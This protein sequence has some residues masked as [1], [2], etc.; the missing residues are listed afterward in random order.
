MPDC[1]PMEIAPVLALA[2]ADGVILS[3]ED[4]DVGGLGSE[5]AE[6]AASTERVPTVRTLVVRGMP[7]SGCFVDDVMAYLDLGVAGIVAA[8]RDNLRHMRRDH[9]HLTSY[10]SY[11]GET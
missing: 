3:V 5:L 10:P 1:P 11:T 9:S 4:N 6:A 8:V 2:P 7:R